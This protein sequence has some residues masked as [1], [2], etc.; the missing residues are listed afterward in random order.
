MEKGRDNGR[1]SLD[2]T[3]KYILIFQYFYNYNLFLIESIY[4]AYCTFFKR[5][6]TLNCVEVKK[7]LIDILFDGIILR[8]VKTIRLTFRPSN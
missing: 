2:C 7:Y 5:S 1:G 3:E 4:I 8:E 6:A